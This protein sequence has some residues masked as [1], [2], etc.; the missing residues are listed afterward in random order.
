MFQ[1]TLRQ[2]A[3][4]EWELK[5]K[6]YYVVNWI[7]LINLRALKIQEKVKNC[8]LV[9]HCMKADSVKKLNFLMN[10]NLPRYLCSLCSIFPVD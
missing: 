6:W 5:K 9:L 2:S 8:N 1:I 7:N 3:G 4:H 10:F